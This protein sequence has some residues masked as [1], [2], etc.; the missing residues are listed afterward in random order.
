M[1]EKNKGKWLKIFAI[2]LVLLAMTFAIV[3]SAVLNSINKKYDDLND[4]N[5]NL[6]E[7]SAQ[8]FDENF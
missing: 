3:T 8:I 2:A 4:K 1:E 5:Q 7:V 6:P